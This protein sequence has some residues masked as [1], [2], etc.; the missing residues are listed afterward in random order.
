MNSDLTS[1]LLL[2]YFAPSNKNKQEFYEYTTKTSYNNSI[3]VLSNEIG[4]DICGNGLYFDYSS[5]SCKGKLTFKSGCNKNCNSCIDANTCITCSIDSS[6][7][8]Y[9]NSNSN[10]CVNVC[11]SDEMVLENTCVVSQYIDFNNINTFDTFFPVN[12]TILDTTFE[13]WVYIPYSKTINVK[14]DLNS[15]ISLNF[16]KYRQEDL[17]FNVVCSLDEIGVSKNSRMSFGIWKNVKCSVKINEQYFYLN[18]RNNS[19]FSSEISKFKVSSNYNSLYLRFI[20]NKNQLGD[21]FFLRNLRIW[22]IYFE[23]YFD[24]SKMYFF[25]IQ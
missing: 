17:F 8:F 21:S 7:Q 15:Q 2:F 19:L 9:L 24:T 25:L 23:D 13:V 14:L 18:E 10:E 5:R 12:Y 1:N 6:K 16:V 20:Q 22:N 3:K 11:K 4:F